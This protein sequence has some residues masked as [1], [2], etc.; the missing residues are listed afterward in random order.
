MVSHLCKVIC[1][2][3]SAIW[4][5]AKNP[6]IEGQG[7]WYKKQKLLVTAVAAQQKW[8]SIASLLPTSHS[9]KQPKS[10]TL[11][12]RR[13]G[14]GAVGTSTPKDILL[15][16]I[17]SHYQSC[18]FLYCSATLDFLGNG[19]NF[20]ISLFSYLKLKLLALLISYCIF[21]TALPSLQEKEAAKE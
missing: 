12:Q 15:S 16:G 8:S 9:C 3:A 2:V 4:V 6:S 5:E 18:L 13:W 7:L 17:F 21:K 14:G 1:K 20:S 19:D 10:D 11:C